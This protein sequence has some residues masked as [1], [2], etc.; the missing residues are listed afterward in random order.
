MTGTST[1]NAK[2]RV[3]LDQNEL[4]KRDQLLTLMLLSTK[5]GGVPIRS[6]FV[7]RSEDMKRPD[8][9]RGASLSKLVTDERALDGF[10]LIHALASSSDPYDVRA[11]A[12]TWA[13][14]VG[15]LETNELLS[16]Q[17]RWSR[18]VA[19][20]KS[21]QLI[22]TKPDGRG[23]RYTLLDE[24]G[25]GSPYVRPQDIQTHGG[26][27]SLPHIYWLEG[28]DRRLRM[29]GKIMLL[30]ALDQ[31][32]KFTLPADRVPKWYGVSR[33]TAQR[34]F[35][36]LENEGILTSTSSTIFDRSA[37]NHYRT[38]KI[39]EAQGLWTKAERRRAMTRVRG[40]AKSAST[41][42]QPPQGAA[43]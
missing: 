5:R 23:T 29:P 33:S 37:P 18:V 39:Y 17:Q 28:Y 11:P 24:S 21:L 27:V 19:K 32:N 6:S 41:G 8:G 1:K 13:Q 2:I 12:A 16:G 38:E 10:L 30:I 4:V 42:S 22:T 43:P 26:W 20:L 40:A 9:S 34:G 7:Q 25:D 31:R 15:L 36:E 14:M 35:T 3:D